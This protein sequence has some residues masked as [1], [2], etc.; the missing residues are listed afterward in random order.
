MVNSGITVWKETEGEEGLVGVSG[1]RVSGGRV[2]GGS[3]SGGRVGGGRV[4]GHAGHVRGTT[5]L[6]QTCAGVYWEFYQD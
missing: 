3:V 2:S 6:T 4:G 1:G 5:P